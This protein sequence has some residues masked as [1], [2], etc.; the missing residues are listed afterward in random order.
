VI[1]DN[2]VTPAETRDVYYVA[3][4]ADGIVRTAHLDGTCDCEW[5]SRRK[6]ADVKVCYHVAAARLWAKPLIRARRAAQRLAA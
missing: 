5:G 2:G 4:E 3:N 1:V 6:S